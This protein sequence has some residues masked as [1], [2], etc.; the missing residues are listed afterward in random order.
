MQ[1]HQN[2]N[3][4]TQPLKPEIST[5]THLAPVAA[6]SSSSCPPK[7]LSGVNRKKPTPTLPLTIEDPSKEKLMSTP[8]TQALLSFAELFP[9]SQRKMYEAD[10][11]HFNIS[12]INFPNISNAHIGAAADCESPLSPQQSRS[13]SMVAVRSP[14]SPITNTHCSRGT[15]F[16]VYNASPSH[17]QTF[18]NKPISSMSNLTK[19]TSTM[20]PQLVANLN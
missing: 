20:L 8:T 16:P 19:G 7:R 4:Q 5:S 3:V 15:S 11:P 12:A 2:Q 18:G 13:P 6:D 10:S 17:S 1:A 9:E 14:L